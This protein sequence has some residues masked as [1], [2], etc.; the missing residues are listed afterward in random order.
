MS[1]FGDSSL[2]LRCNE[3]CLLSPA[4]MQRLRF[5]SL[6]LF[7]ISDIR[8]TG[9][10]STFRIL[11]QLQRTFARISSAIF[12]NQTQSLS[13][14]EVHTSERKSLI[15]MQYALSFLKKNTR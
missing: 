9:S 12:S 10:V 1:R 3:F 6:P 13:R 2:Q 8:I 14:S 11:I 7:G 5:Q 15:R 4:T